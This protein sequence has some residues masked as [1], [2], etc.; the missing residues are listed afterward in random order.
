VTREQFEKT[1]FAEIL[2]GQPCVTNV[3]KKIT[4]VIAGKGTKKYHKI[5]A[6]KVANGLNSAEEMFAVLQIIAGG[7]TQRGYSMDR[8]ALMALAKDMVD[9]A[10]GKR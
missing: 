5:Q 9:E 1:W 10:E 7:K 3:G 4:M 8:S 2:A 6:Q